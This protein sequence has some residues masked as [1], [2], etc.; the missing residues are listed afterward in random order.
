MIKDIH[1]L[2][3]TVF[4]LTVSSVEAQ[5]PK[6]VYRIGVLLIAPRIEYP[7]SEGVRV[8]SAR[9]WL[10]RRTEHRDRVPL[11]G[12]EARSVT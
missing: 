8:G 9:A 10:H 5:Q 11:C 7:R 12:G 6:K 4:L 2:P 3:L 1:L